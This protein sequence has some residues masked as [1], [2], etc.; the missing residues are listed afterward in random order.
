M[1]D[2]IIIGAGGVGREV[3]WIIEE[4]NKVEETWNIKGVVDDNKE[5]WG[6]NINNYKVLG[7][8]DILL[9]FPKDIYI[10]IAISNYKI[11]KE[12]V[13]FIGDKYRY[14]NIIH[15]SV[16]I[17]K[18]S[19]IGEGII[20]YPGVVITTNIKIQNHVII[21]PKCGI[22][23]NSVLE[24]YVSLLWNA[25][26][27]G[28][29]KIEEGAMIGTGAT[30]IQYKKIGMGSVVGAGAVVINNVNENDVV[31]GVPAKSI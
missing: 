18:T 5:L 28:F 15:P 3:L 17:S 25:N 2:L 12:L 21:S 13:E 14:A 23:H 1:K 27:S 24:D 16:F 31:A 10:I 30:I 11:K 26:I 29:V 8:R 6:K 19:E 4:I 7:G 22:G 9:S 20:I